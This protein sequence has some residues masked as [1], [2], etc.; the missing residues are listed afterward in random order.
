LVQEN[1]YREKNLKLE[2]MMMMTIQA[3]DGNM[4]SRDRFPEELNW[5]KVTL[6]QIHN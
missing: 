4:S 1:N 2:E 6:P 5:I 3:T